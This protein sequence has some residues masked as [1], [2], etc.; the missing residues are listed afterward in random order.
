MLKK[1][2]VAVSAILACITYM[3]GR[4]TDGVFYKTLYC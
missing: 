2:D 4:T 1:E 3:Y